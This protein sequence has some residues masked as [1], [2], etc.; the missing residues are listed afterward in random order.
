MPGMS[1][2]PPRFDNIPQARTVF[3]QIRRLQA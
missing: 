2:Q 1:A 3:E